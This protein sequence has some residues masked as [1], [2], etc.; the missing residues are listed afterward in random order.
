VLLHIL[1]HGWISSFHSRHKAGSSG[2]M[3]LEK[4]EENAV[5]GEL[6]ASC[7]ELRRPRRHWTRAAAVN[8]EPTTAIQRLE[9]HVA[10][11]PGEPRVGDLGD[12]HQRRSILHRTLPR[13]A[14]C[15]F[16]PGHTPTPPRPAQ[17]EAGKGGASVDA[18]AR[19]GRCSNWCGGKMN[20]ER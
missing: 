7:W 12:S 9:E 18:L 11:E 6:R 14:A 1:A 8:S 19:T 4:E 20:E 16:D 2:E 17:L 3:E 15:W 5:K 13:S 10:A